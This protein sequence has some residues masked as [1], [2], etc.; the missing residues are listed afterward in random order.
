MT[1][2]PHHSWADGE[3]ACY[4]HS[5]RGVRGD[6]QKASRNLARFLDGCPPAPDVLICFAELLKMTVLDSRTG[7]P[8]GRFSVRTCLRTPQYVYVCVCPPASPGQTQ[9]AEPQ[10]GW[11]LISALSST[12]GVRYSAAGRVVWFSCAWD[13]S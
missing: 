12:S 4:I 6:N 2:R 1:D 13:S 10:A 7:A 8:Q 3:T 9:P 11:Q 5:Y